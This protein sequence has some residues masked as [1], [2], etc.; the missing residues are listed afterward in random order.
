MF[1]SSKNLIADCKLQV[2]AM[3]T[4]IF[5]QAKSSFINEEIQFL[6]WGEST[7]EQILVSVVLE[8]CVCCC[9]LPVDKSCVSRSG[10]KL[11]SLKIY[12]STFLL[13]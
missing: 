1:N 5:E 6:I 3:H 7:V 9:H 4:R 10:S 12:V 13:C 11:F 2:V 8:V